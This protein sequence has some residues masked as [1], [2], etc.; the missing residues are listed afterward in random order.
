VVLG[1]GDTGSDCI[2]TSHRLGAKSVT[3]I[4]LMGKP[5]ESRIPNNPWPHWPQVLRTSSSQEEGGE[6]QWS[7]LTRRFVS[8]DGIHLSGIEVVK[9]EWE[10]DEHGQY[11]MTE[12][13]DEV[14][15]LPCEKAFLAIGF[16]HGKR[17][18]LLTELGV[19][20]DQSGNVSTNNYATSV[21]NVFAAGDMRRG[22]SLV[23]WA[24][25]EGRACAQEVHHH[26]SASKSKEKPTKDL[27]YAL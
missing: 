14:D 10:K 6:R 17:E 8:N 21:D 23:V 9:V 26:L 3:Q 7:V 11:K 20:I 18:G 12:K 5:P 16:L 27:A 1:G 24:I 19:E 22:Q 13:P 2:G 25:A 4:E 15:I